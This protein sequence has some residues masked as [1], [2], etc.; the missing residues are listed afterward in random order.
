MASW[1]GE[2]CDYLFDA[3]KELK[4]KYKVDILNPYQSEEVQ[5][6]C[7]IFYDKFYS[8]KGKRNLIFGINPGRL[9]AGITGLSFTDPHKL[10]FE[11]GIPNSFSK[12]EELSS[13]FIYLWINHSHTV[14]SF[15]KKHIILSVCPLG[16]I[17]AGKNV[18]YYDD[19]RLEKHCEK[20]IVQ[21]QNFIHDEFNVGK[22]AYVLGKGKNFVYLKKLNEKHGWYDEVIALPHPRWVMQYRYKKRFEIMDDMTAILNA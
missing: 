10:E 13:R 7:R 18:N 4:P 1:H 17:Q 22:K 2:Y 15:Y 21:H 20:F 16:F 8:D 12:K 3:Y 9:G 19:K 5:T 6:C 11:C 14:K